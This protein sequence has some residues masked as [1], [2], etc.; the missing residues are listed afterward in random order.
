MIKDKTNEKYSKYQKYILENENNENEL[1]KIPL[2]K[3]RFLQYLNKEYDKIHI[4]TKQTVDSFC[5]IW[6]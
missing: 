1:V 2:T 3:K 6:G 5:E 4:D